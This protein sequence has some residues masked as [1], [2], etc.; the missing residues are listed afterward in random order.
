MDGWYNLRMNYHFLKAKGQPGVDLS[1]EMDLD[2]KLVTIL[3]A[4][5][6]LFDSRNRDAHDKEDRNNIFQP[7]FDNFDDKSTTIT[8]HVFAWRRLRSLQR[9][10][11]S[12]L[13][14]RYPTKNIP[15]IFHVDGDPLGA[16]VNYLE[17]FYW[18][19]GIKTLDFSPSRKGM[20]MVTLRLN[21][22][23]IAL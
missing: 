12:L 21:D 5:Y 16:V 20:P 6:F 19:F 22:G 11:K 23:P 14:A 15:L 1:R 17:S 3:L 18:P 2:L 13:N 9:L 7:D 8:L 10:C 4:L